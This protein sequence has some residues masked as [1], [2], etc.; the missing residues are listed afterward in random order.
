MLSRKT[1]DTRS[2]GSNLN[3]GVLEGGLCEDSIFI[4]EFVCRSLGVPKCNSHLRV[5]SGPFLLL[6]WKCGPDKVV[7]YCLV[8]VIAC[9]PGKI[10]PLRFMLGTDPNM[11]LYN[12]LCCAVGR[13]NSME[14]CICIHNVFHFHVTSAI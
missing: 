1:P 10:K 4:H 7:M 13:K 3:F 14:K 5:Q 2:L 8:S 11:T 12:R 6:N 9:L